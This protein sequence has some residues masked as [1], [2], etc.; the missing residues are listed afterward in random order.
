[1]KTVWI[2]KEKIESSSS[3]DHVVHVT[4]KFNRFTSLSERER[5]R[6]IFFFVCA[7]DRKLAVKKFKKI[8]SRGVPKNVELIQI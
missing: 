4:I 3:G 2:L 8:N 5:H 7:G 1:M 6:N